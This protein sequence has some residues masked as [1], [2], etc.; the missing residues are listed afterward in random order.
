MQTNNVITLRPGRLD[1]PLEPQAVGKLSSAVFVIVG[2]IP[3]DMEGLT[4][5]I[6]RTP[7]GT[8]PR[9]N[10]T[11]ATVRQDD[12]SYRCYLSPFYFPD[13]SEALKYHI[14]GQDSHEAPR[15][16][17]SGNLRIF[18]NPA[19]GSSVTP[20]VIPPDTY[21]RNPITGKYHKLT[22]ALN[23]L[24]ELTIDVDTEGIDR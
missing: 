3:A 20:E 23:A 21:V 8:T 22:A 14:I 7:D 13:A 6:E 4:V 24:G 10:F 15:W 11:A 5:Q 17:G 16:L 9:P 1:L 2:E 12:G 19:N 18:D